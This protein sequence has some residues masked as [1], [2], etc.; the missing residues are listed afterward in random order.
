MLD[1]KSSHVRY[2]FSTSP[3]PVSTGISSSLVWTAVDPAAA[4]FLATEFKFEH[5]PKV[6]G[7]FGGQFHKNGSHNVL[8]SVWDAST[9]LKTAHPDART[10]SRFGGEGEGAH[11]STPINWTVGVVYQFH[12]QQLQQNAS[13]TAWGMSVWY[14]EPNS[15]VHVFLPV[16]RIFLVDAPGASPGSGYG[17]LLPWALSFQEY[18]LGVP[19]EFHSA[20]GWIGPYMW[21]RPL[22]P[23]D[24]AVPDCDRC[25][26]VSACIPGVGCGRP[27]AFFEHGKAVMQNCTSGANMWK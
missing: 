21:S 1:P 25:E 10:C 2:N 20:A 24:V 23:P 16:G 3:P 19:P 14:T 27:N 8:F 26:A 15:T 11:C 7:Y 22:T 18:F 17:G 13:G 9:T 12:V 4:V 5:G 6:G